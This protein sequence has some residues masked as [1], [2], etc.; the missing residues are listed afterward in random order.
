MNLT[1]GTNSFHS[2]NSW[3]IHIPSQRREVSHYGFVAQ[4][5]AR[6]KPRGTPDVAAFADQAA[7]NTGVA[8]DG[9]TGPDHGV[10]DVYPFVDL[11]IVPDDRV[12]DSNAFTDC[13]IGSNDRFLIHEG[14]RG[15]CLSIECTLSDA[16]RNK[17]P[18]QDI[19]MDFEIFLRCADIDPVLIEHVRHHRL[20]VLQQRWKES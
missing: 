15:H 5:H 13:N 12:L 16:R 7:R 10:D 9:I 6:P 20:F 4:N 8:V 19:V 14:A 1:N 11:A 17:L 18:R 2:L 3:L